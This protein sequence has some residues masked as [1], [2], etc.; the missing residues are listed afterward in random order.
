[1]PQLI[2]ELA[3]KPKTSTRRITVTV[4]ESDYDYIVATAR[5]NTSAPAT[6][7]AAILRIGLA[8]LREA[9]EE[10]ARE[11]RMADARRIGW[12]GPDIPDVPPMA[13]G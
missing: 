5:A 2:E 7:A 1:M 8:E 10:E 11:Q 12:N 3:S 6:A 13:L 4:T 9:D